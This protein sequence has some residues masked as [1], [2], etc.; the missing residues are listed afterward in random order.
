[1]E[2][3][4]SRMIR[5]HDIGQTTRENQALG[6]QEQYSHVKNVFQYIIIFC[7]IQFMFTLLLDNS[8]PGT[9]K[10]HE[11]GWPFWW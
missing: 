2:C 7:K 6:S 8:L 1:M 5:Y 4:C 3:S 9:A 10:T 11:Q